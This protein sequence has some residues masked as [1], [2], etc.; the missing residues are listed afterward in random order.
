MITK[1]LG[2]GLLLIIF[3]MKYRHLLLTG[4]GYLSLTHSF[5]VI[6]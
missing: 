1:M 6:P 2:N 3:F 4:G 5:E